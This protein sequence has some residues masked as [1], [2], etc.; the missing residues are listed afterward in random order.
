MAAYLH[1]WS[2]LSPN[3]EMITYL[4]LLL[5]RYFLCKGFKSK[6][7]GHGTLPVYSDPLMVDQL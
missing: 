3:L 1:V 5:A 6:S 2:D 7:L 4:F